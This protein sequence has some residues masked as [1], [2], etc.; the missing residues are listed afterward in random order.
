M[1]HFFSEFLMRR[2]LV[3]LKNFYISGMH[4]F[5]MPHFP[6]YSPI[7]I[8]PN[9]SFNK[10]FHCC[11][12]LNI[13]FRFQI[14]ERIPVAGCPFAC[15]APHFAICLPGRN[16]NICTFFPYGKIENF[17]VFFPPLGLQ[18]WLHWVGLHCRAFWGWRQM[19]AVR[20]ESKFQCSSPSATTAAIGTIWAGAAAAKIA[21]FPTA[22]TI[23]HRRRYESV[24]FFVGFPRPKPPGHWCRR[25]AKPTEHF[26][27]RHGIAKLFCRNNGQQQQQWHNVVKVGIVWTVPRS[28]PAW[29]PSAASNNGNRRDGRVW[30]HR[31]EEPKQCKWNAADAKWFRWHVDQVG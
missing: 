29:T 16:W 14:S 17:H 28:V 3:Q 9:Y 1:P 20:V 22:T 23:A 6:L 4:I 24:Q 31:N 2:N 26:W 11:K 18:P 25:A 21:A 7:N 27:R 30:R 13:Y 5:Y 15:C 8:S 19:P 10:N 12:I